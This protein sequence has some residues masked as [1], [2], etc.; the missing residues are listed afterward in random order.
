MYPYV[1][2]SIINDGQDMEKTEVSLDRQLDK[3]DVVRI[4]GGILLS[5][6]E[7]L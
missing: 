7:R 4:Y 6:K 3:E 1:H 2:R 5:H